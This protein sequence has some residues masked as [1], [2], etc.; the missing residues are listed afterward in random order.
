MIPSTKVRTSLE[1]S[2]LLKKGDNEVVVEVRSGIEDR[3]VVI[4]GQPIMPGKVLKGWE[5]TGGNGAEPFYTLG[6]WQGI[7]L[8]MVSNVHLE[9]PFLITQF[10]S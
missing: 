2:K 9:R 3:P 10:F 6:M 7:R 5:F 4:K 8:E 1:V